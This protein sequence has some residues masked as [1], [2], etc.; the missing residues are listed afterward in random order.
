MVKNF[1]YIFV[2]PYIRLKKVLSLSIVRYWWSSLFNPVARLS[3]SPSGVLLFV[4]NRKVRIITFPSRTFSAQ[5]AQLNIKIIIFNKQ[6]PRL[7]ALYFSVFYRKE[8]KILIKASVRGS[9][10]VRQAAAMHATV[11]KPAGLI[12]KKNLSHPALFLSGASAH[13]R[14]E[15]NPNQQ[16]RPDG[17]ALR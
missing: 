5:I 4:R 14:W 8:N 10:A 13:S 16:R 9:R 3:F 6:L 7:I 2:I 15:R 12:R 1:F 17:Y 11:Y